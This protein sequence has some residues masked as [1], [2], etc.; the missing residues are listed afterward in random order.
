MESRLVIMLIMRTYY[1]GNVRIEMT[2]PNAS[3]MYGNIDD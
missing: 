3:A 1:G 2:S